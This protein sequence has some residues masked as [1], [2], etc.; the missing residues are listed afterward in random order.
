MQPYWS[1]WSGYKALHNDTYFLLADRAMCVPLLK[2]T[3][4]RRLDS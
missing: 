4:T 1:Q 3:A 2:S